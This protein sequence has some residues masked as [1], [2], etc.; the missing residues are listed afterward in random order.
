M[1]C[2]IKYLYYNIINVSIEKSRR[3]FVKR[4]VMMYL[5]VVRYGRFYFLFF[6]FNLLWLSKFLRWPYIAWKYRTLYIP[7]CWKYL[8]WKTSACSTVRKKRTLSH[9]EWLLILLFCFSCITKFFWIQIFLPL[10]CSPA[11][12]FCKCRR[13]TSCTTLYHLYLYHLPIPHHQ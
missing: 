13:S 5:W 9:N 12:G 10:A 1:F 2:E 8:H 6:S 7:Y 3:I 11:E 4:L